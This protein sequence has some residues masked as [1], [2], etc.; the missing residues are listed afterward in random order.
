MQ[1]FKLRIFEEDHPGESFPEFS[2]LSVEAMEVLRSALVRR[3]RFEGEYDGVKFLKFL[4]A[5]SRSV[6]G[7]NAQSAEFNLLSLLRSLRVKPRENVYI[8]WYR[9]DDIDV[10]R[11]TD[12]SKHFDDV[13]YTEDI[14]IFDDSL[15]WVLAIEEDGFVEFLDLT[16]EG[17]GS[18]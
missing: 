12:L 1:D 10:M 7:V 11:T 14:D 18:Q 3:S 13:R 8:N 9:F 17:D 16:S 5:K 6:E 4:R 15:S 2:E